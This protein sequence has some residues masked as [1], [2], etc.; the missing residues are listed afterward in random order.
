M[1]ISPITSI[2]HYCLN[3]STLLLLS[4]SW[5]SCGCVPCLWAISTTI[6]ESY[7]VLQW[8]CSALTWCCW[9][10]L[11]IFSII[12]PRFHL[13]PMLVCSSQFLSSWCLLPL[14]LSLKCLRNHEHLVDLT[15]FLLIFWKSGEEWVFY[16]HQNGVLIFFLPPNLFSSITRVFF[17]LLRTSAFLHGEYTLPAAVSSRSI[18]NFLA[19]YF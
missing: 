8:S 17:V 9:L 6:L 10:V 5:G 12:C 1:P 13:E 16:G 7:F 3:Y 4:I 2:S 14:S 15:A 18:A 11:S 19:F